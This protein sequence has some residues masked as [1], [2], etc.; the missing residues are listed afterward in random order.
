MPLERRAAGCVDVDL[1]HRRVP[2]HTVVDPG[3]LEAAREHE[4][5]RRVDHA[6]PR[7]VR[8][9][10]EP[11]RDRGRQC[12]AGDPPRQ[13]ERRREQAD[14]EEREGEA[15]GGGPRP[16]EL[17]LDPQPERAGD[18]VDPGFVRQ[19]RE[20]QDEHERQRGDRADRGRDAGPRKAGGEPPTR[21]TSH[22][23]TR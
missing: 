20:R 5:L 19:L 12:E 8:H 23:G 22:S 7:E 2:R 21:P 9:R 11:D 13:E 10:R 14:D 18:G 4:V 6:L 17:R 15:A 1:R 3:A 16:R